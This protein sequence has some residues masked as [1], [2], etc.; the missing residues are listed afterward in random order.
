[1]SFGCW[2]HKYSVLSFFDEESYLHTDAKYQTKGD[3]RNLGIFMTSLAL[4]LSVVRLRMNSIG[5]LLLGLNPLEGDGTYISIK[6]ACSGSSVIFRV[7]SIE[8]N[9]FIYSTL[10]IQSAR[11]LFRV[12]HKIAVIIEILLEID[13]TIAYKFMPILL[14]FHNV[15]F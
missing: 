4:V 5:R 15:I 8:Y 13:F 10:P 2:F 12:P 14:V 9:L 6:A 11:K 3:V 1:M 7:M